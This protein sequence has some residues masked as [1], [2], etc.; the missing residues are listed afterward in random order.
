MKIDGSLGEGGGQIL[1]TSAAL[2][3][4][5]GEKISL[6]R[7]RAGRREPGLRPQHLTALEILKKISDAATDGLKVGSEEIEFD[8]GEPKG[9]EYEFDIGTAGSVTLVFETLVL[10]LHGSKERYVIDIT[11]GTDV[12]WSPPWDHFEHV[13]LPI[14]RSMG[15][16]VQAELMRRGHHPRGGGKARL[17]MGGGPSG[18]RGIEHEPKN[19]PWE[20]KGKIHLS[21]LPVHIAKRMR[22]SASK[23]LMRSDLVPEIHI[24]RGGPLSTGT[25][26]VLWARSG[27]SLIGSSCLGRKGVPAEKIGE[28][29]A[30]DLLREIDSG[31]SVDVHT[32]DQIIPLMGIAKGSRCFVREIT[33]HIRTNIGVV[34]DFLNLRFDIDEESDPISI[35]I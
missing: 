12:R 18:P 10:G 20:V 34:E 31:A 4:F 19:G 11:G 28:E 35:R 2:S 8:P 23:M 17:I 33:G 15:I 26:I 30:G 32:M 5:T 9:G 22:K 21:N 29:A 6:D 24:E 13:Y 3:V 7:I 27:Q 16:D 14:I 25:G 1:R